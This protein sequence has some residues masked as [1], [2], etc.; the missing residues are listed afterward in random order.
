M[1]DQ[2]VNFYLNEHSIEIMD[3]LE[4]I[5]K[6]FYQIISE[7]KRSE[8]HIKGKDLTFEHVKEDVRIRK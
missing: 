4:S 8:I 3:K 6:K 1:Q 7:I 2:P 5:N